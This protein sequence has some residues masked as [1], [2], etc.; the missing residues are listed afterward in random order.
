MVCCV[1]SISNTL[2][3]V[4]D[5][6]AG[7]SIKKLRHISRDPTTLS[8]IYPNVNLSSSIRY[9][10]LDYLIQI[11]ITEHKYKV[12][13]LYPG[14]F[15]DISMVVEFLG[16]IQLP[17]ILSISNKGPNGFSKMNHV[18]GLYRNNI[19]D[20]EYTHNRILNEENL[21]LACGEMSI[22]TGYVKDTY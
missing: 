15:T 8:Q 3:F 19:I 16:A 6:E 18:I 21:H 10:E 13:N 5:S 14:V 12:Q 22:S 9:N 11:L 7:E 2:Y 4:G 1:S 17:M 20:G